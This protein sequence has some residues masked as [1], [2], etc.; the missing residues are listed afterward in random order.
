MGTRTPLSLS[1]L[2]NRGAPCAQGVALDGDD[3]VPA[4]VVGHMGDDDLGAA[5]VLRERPLREWG[6]GRLSGPA[7]A[8]G[9]CRL[10]AR[11]S[12]APAGR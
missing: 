11:T 8:P 7:T 5:E 3:G 2:R 4:V 10:R 9:P 12:P 6:R 1:F